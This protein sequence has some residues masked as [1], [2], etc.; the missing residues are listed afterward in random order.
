V[1][2]VLV[3]EDNADLAYGLRNNLEIEGYKV[4]VAGDGTR[5]LALARTA[6]PDLIILDLMLPGMDGFRV[7]RALRDE[8]RRLPILVLTARGE[9]GDKVR[10]LRLG[11]DD[12]VTKPFGVLEL[13]ARVEA[14]FR[15]AGSA[16][17][18]PPT[19]AEREHFGDV[20]VVP[21]SRT[22]LRQGKAV[23]L[24]PK[25]Y[26]LLIALLRRR[27]AVASRTE[28]LTEVWGYSATVLSRTVD[29]HVAE[30]RSKLERDAAQPQHILTV[31]KAG[32]RLER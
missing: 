11:A 23:T 5:G 9:E 19:L 25:E 7:L 31:R 22:V 26:D 21:A 6:G 13:L 24:T 32:Y 1:K 8:G 3:V 14:L 2:R 12:Y 10:G 17:A 4:D 20:E 27:G 18:A 29:T 28:L 30:L 15:R 16:A